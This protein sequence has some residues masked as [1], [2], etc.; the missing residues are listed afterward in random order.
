MELIEGRTLRELLDSGSMPVLKVIQI[1]AQIADGLAKAHEAGIIHRDLKPE[2][3]MLSSEGLVKI[4]DFGLAKLAAAGADF[5]SM[6]TIDLQTSPGAV[7][8]TVEYMSPEQASGASIDFR[9]DQFS[10]GLVLYEMVTGKQAYQRNTKPETLVAII[11][12]APEPIVLCLRMSPF[13]CAGSSS[14]ALPGSPRSAT[15]QRVTLHA[16]SPLCATTYRGCN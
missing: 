10:F 15:C 16:T 7:L 2:N 4:L 8:G 14:A 5:F 11:R 12:E 6:G 13:Q 9:S 1:A 3:L